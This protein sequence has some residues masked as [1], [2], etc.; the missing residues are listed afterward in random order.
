MPILKHAKKKLRVDER[1]ARV[2]KKIRTKSRKAVKIARKEPSE[3][4][5]RQ[6]F[7]MLDRAAKRKIL[8]KRRADRIK[9]RLSKLVVSSSKPETKQK[10]SK[11]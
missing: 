9:S 11:K 3:G 7:S 5:L 10:K 2:N 6:A 8:P 1:R 4:A